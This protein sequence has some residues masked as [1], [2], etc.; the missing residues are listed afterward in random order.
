LQKVALLSEKSP[1]LVENYQILISCLWR[2]FDSLTIA[3]A[4]ETRQPLKTAVP[5][6]AISVCK[7]SREYNRRRRRRRR[8][9]R[10]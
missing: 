2:M 10:F 5:F 6:C 4:Q 3:D 8:R 7:H 9:R 1:N